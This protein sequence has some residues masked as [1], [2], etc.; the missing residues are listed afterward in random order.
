MTEKLLTGTISLNTKV[1]K[2]LHMQ[3]D[4][5]NA[6]TTNDMSH[7]IE[8]LYVVGTGRISTCSPYRFLD[9][10][11]SCIRALRIGILF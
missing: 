6:S 4:Y 9:A 11:V 5:C 8:V 2:T 3:R 7:D 1:R 10:N